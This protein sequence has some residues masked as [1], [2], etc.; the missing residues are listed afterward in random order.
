VIYARIVNFS[1][2]Y[3]KCYKF[4]PLIGIRDSDFKFID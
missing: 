3:D 2:I 1:N 4:D